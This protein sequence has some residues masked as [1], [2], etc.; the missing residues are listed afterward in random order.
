M[1]GETPPPSYRATAGDALV[2]TLLYAV[3]AGLWILVSDRLVT[4]MFSDPLHLAVANT[5]KGWVFVAVTTALLYALLRRRRHWQAAEAPPAAVGRRFSWPLLAIL[6]LIVGATAAAIAYNF[7]HQRQAAEARL[8]AI[9]DLKVRQ[10]GD[11]LWERHGDAEFVQSSAYFAEQYALWVERGH[12]DAGQRLRTRLEQLRLSRGFGGISLFDPSGRRLWGSSGAPAATAPALAEAVAQSR[13]GLV[14]RVGPYV[15]R[16]GHA[17]LDFVA[18]LTAAAGAPPVIVL[19]VD[20]AEWLFPM[21]QTWPVPSASDETL[22]FRRDG[23]QVEFLNEL[24]YRK[25][26]TASFRLPLADAGQL[27]AQVLRGEAREGALMV[28]WDYRG[29]PAL[30]VARAVAGTDWYLLAKMDRAEVYAQAV[31][32]AVWTGLSGVLALFIA[33][34]SLVMLRQRNRLAIAESTRQAET[35]RLR[36]LKLLEAFAESSDDAIFAKD[37]EGRYILFNRAAGLFVGQPAEAVLGRVDR[38]LFPPGQA[39][40]LRAGDQAAIRENRNHTE[41]EALD[42]PLGTRV[43]LTTKGP[44]RDEHDRVIG[45]FGIS[46]DITESR[47]AQD[48]LADQMRRFHMLL[49]S[50]RD[51]IAILDEE[52]RVIEANRRLADMLGYAPEELLRLHAWDFDVQPREPRGVME[53]AGPERRVFETRY[54]RKD[55]SLYDVEVSASSAVWGGRRLLLCICRDITKRKR[56]E[57]AVH[58]S[59]ARYRAL[60]EQSLA[61]IYIIQD[62]RFRFV[63]RGFA[64]IFGYDSP[65]EILERVP[66]TDLVAPGD[67]A[68]V[69]ENVRRRVEGEVGD[70]HYVFKGRRRDGSTIDVEVHGRAFNYEGRAA[71]IGLILDITARKAAEDALRASELRFHDIV[72]ASAD[73]VWEVDAQGRYTYASESVRDLLGYT[74]EE[75]IGR[76]PFDLMPAGEAERVSAE[77]AAI[78]ARKAPFRDLDNVNVHRDGS[79]RYVQTNGMPILDAAGKLLGYRGLDRDVTGRKLA[80]LE[81]RESEARFRALFDNAAV[82]IMIHD[83]DSGEIVEANRQAIES[84]GCATLEELRG[85]GLWCEPPYSL[86]DAVARIRK[87]AEEGPQHFEWKSHDRQGREFW[88]DV[89]LKKMAL[90]GVERVLSVTTDITARKVAEAELKE[91]NAELERFNRATVGREL[92]MIELKKQVNELARALGREA[93]YPLDFL[94]GNR[95]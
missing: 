91:R 81:L 34:A 95:E 85:G 69:A 74:A 36:A 48:E 71:V 26:T 60:V 53:D 70:I 86:E 67:R 80:E 18:P 76:T 31:E 46:R 65:D 55:G 42:T 7:K 33:L 11:W 30:G 50:S 40:R 20:P 57:A 66:F 49:D 1:N 68:R 13:D 38:E 22:L 72:N 54:R 52:Q 64:A 4:W 58:E 25:G 93:P 83:K 15:G 75:I 44:L 92:D 47:L 94:R 59:E 10:V 5:L 45:T 87:A 79:L 12:A 35:E 24:R 78:I 62:G 28:G 19:H 17:R 2:P 39:E 82:A 27:S 3:F 21:L 89:L 23:R 56:A 84:Y 32:G 63:N 51:G 16:A 73:W 29:V 6:L 90:N 9:A 41:E 8:Q 88:E 61:G 43:F 77:F 14:R 37:L